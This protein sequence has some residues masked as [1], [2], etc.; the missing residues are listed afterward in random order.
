M[1]PHEFSAADLI[2]NNLRDLTP[3]A[4]AAVFG[5][6]IRHSRSPE[7]HNAALQ[8]AGIDAQYIRIHVRKEDLAAS[9]RA[10]PTAGFVGANIT[11]PHKIET[12]KLLDQIDDHARI[13][14]AVN[15]VSVESNHQLKGYNTDGPGL[16]RAVREEF[17]VD[18]SDLR[19][20][21][22]GAGGGAGQAIAAQCVLEGCE[23]LVL[24]NRSLDKIQA[25]KKRL[26]PFLL[27]ERLQGP[28]D[29]LIAIGLDES[30]LARELPR[31]DLLINT[32]SVGL[33]ASEPQLI[34]KHILSPHLLVYDTVYSSA[35]TRLLAD[36]EAK[37]ARVANG[38]S[39]LLHQ[40]ALAFEIWFHRSPSL[41]AMRRGL[42]ANR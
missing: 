2:H 6:P 23:R 41:A 5:D 8:V 20:L 14:G 24:A 38:L 30:S 31:I 4:K 42:T 39:M 32:T 1:T 27:N 7:M 29:R 22:L 3:P 25:L 16:V 28:T 11:I 34:P 9:L 12:L 21:I 10:L 35:K 15:T 40:G 26:E 18:I 36:A 13:L 19:I 17:Q 33:S 37:G